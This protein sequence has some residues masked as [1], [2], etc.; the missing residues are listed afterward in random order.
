MDDAM[1]T[2]PAPHVFLSHVREDALCVERLSAGLGAR[3]IGTWLDRHQIRP[4]ERWERAI[5]GAIRSGAF[6]VAC[7]SQAY[8]AKP[9]S[10]MNEE[11]H[12]ATREVRRRPLDRAWFLPIRL[13]DC[14]IPDWPI[15]P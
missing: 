6:F 8:A 4:G 14:E 5:E 11:L 9:T 1:V 13:D 15:G 12:I 10:Y 3:G 2:E 7:F